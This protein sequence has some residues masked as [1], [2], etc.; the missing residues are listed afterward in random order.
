MKS[1]DPDQE[2]TSNALHWQ[3]IS[4]PL[5]LQAAVLKTTAD[6]LDLALPDFPGKGYTLS[7]INYKEMCASGPATGLKTRNNPQVP[8]WA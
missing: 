8:G 1:Q 3:V 4:L 5:G 2:K 7:F 6:G